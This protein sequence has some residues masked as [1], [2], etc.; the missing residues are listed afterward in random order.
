MSKLLYV[1]TEG[2]GNAVL[3]LPAIEALYNAG[4]PFRFWESIP[5]LT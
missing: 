4:T 2:I 3:A 5:P 1:M